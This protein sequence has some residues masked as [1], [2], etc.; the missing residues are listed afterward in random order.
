MKNLDLPKTC[1]FKKIL[2]GSNIYIQGGYI[3]NGHWLFSIAWLESLPRTRALG[4]LSLKNRVVK[5][6]AKAVG[7]RI[8]GTG[9]TRK[10]DLEKIVNSVK[11][12]DYTP[13]PLGGIEF[14]QGYL[15]GDESNYTEVA[16][17]F[18]SEQKVIVDIEYAAALFFDTS[19]MIYISGGTAPVMMKNAAGDIVALIMPLNPDNYNPMEKR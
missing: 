5:E 13:A 10:V 11:P 12:S 4:L 17:T 15:R 1:V 18:K 6:L 7:Q 9:T 8:S 3:S 14:I 2:K 16:L 19:T